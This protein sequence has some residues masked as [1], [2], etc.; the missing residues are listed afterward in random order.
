[1]LAK[2][3]KF[4]HD[5]ELSDSTQEALASVAHAAFADAKGTDWKKQQYPVLLENALRLLVAV[6]PDV[7]TS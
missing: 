5:P 4:W 1:V 7:Q 6:S 3:V 2:A